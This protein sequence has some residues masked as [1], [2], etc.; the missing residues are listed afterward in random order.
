MTVTTG[1]AASKHTEH[2]DNLHIIE[3]IISEQ[4]Q[5]KIPL[6]VYMDS[7]RLPWLPSPFCWHQLPG[8]AYSLAGSHWPKVTTSMHDYFVFVC[9]ISYV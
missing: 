4:V 6:L 2:N 8:S 3:H 9:S 5:Y 1:P 7:C